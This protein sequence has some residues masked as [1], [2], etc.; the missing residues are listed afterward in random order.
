VKSLKIYIISTNF[1]IY[2]HEVERME[3]KNVVSIHANM[4]RVQCALTLSLNTKALK[5]Y[6]VQYTNKLNNN[7]YS[8]PYINSEYLH[9]PC[10]HE[11]VM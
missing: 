10:A 1:N 3:L 9:L 11:E 5:K 8:C 7:N 4:G 6:D 2:Y